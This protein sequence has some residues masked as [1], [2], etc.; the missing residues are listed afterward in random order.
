[1]SFKNLEQRYN[2]NT[3][4]LYTGAKTKFEG[5]KPTTGASD[6]PILV[7]APGDNQ[8]GLKTEGR[9]LPFVSGPRDV[10]RLTLF[11]FSKGGLLFLAKQQLLQTGNTFEYT[12][13]LNPLFVIGNAVPFVHLKRS[14]RSLKLKGPLGISITLG[15]NDKVVKGPVNSSSRGNLNRIAQ[16]QQETFDK[17]RT[18]NIGGLIK[19]VLTASP[20]GKLVSGATAKRSVGDSDDL[21][22]RYTNSRPELMKNAIASLFGGITSAINSALGTQFEPDTDYI[23]YK[24]IAGGQY[25]LGKTINIKLLY[26]PTGFSYSTY[27]SLTDNKSKWT[28]VDLGYTSHDSQSSTAKK[29]NLESKVTESDPETY[30]KNPVNFGNADDYREDSVLSPTTDV[31]ENDIRTDLLTAGQR[32]ELKTRW[33][34]DIETEMQGYIETSHTLADDFINEITEGNIEKQPFLKYFTAGDD[35]SITSDAQWTNANAKYLTRELRR[36][37]NTKKISYIRDP[38]NSPANPLNTDLDIPYQTLPIPVANEADPNDPI[39]VS[40]AMGKNPHVQFRAFIRDLQQSINPE[41]KQYQYIGRIEK[42]INFTSVQRKISFKLDIIAF[43]KNELSTVWTRINYLTGLVFPYGYT[44]GI[45]QP[46]IARLTIGKVYEDQPGYFSSI[47]TVFNE[48]SET[49]DI[50]RKVPIAATMNVEYIIIEKNTKIAT[51]P[52]YAI[53]E[54]LGNQFAPVEASLPSTTTTAT[55][56]AATSSPPIQLPVEKSPS[57][58]QAIRSST[59]TIPVPSTFNGFGGGGGFSGGGAGGR[60]P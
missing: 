19:K 9:G 36:A 46:N 17:F 31:A 40:I 38:L 42:F 50:D 7:R 48:I 35:Q 8:S 6:D 16:L 12:R 33:E 58:Q 25:N 21:K 32:L 5:G 18:L 3:K 2:E 14:T 44:R 30:Y 13:V 52:F 45:L 43:S 49:W 23:M 53:T 11:Q 60:F 26:G 47:N 34:Q 37:G 20:I 10:K 29:N 51:S 4:K 39:L 27:L 24:Q 1:M 55:A 59:T 57:L 56:P 22:K 15:S 54:D 41:Y 28:H